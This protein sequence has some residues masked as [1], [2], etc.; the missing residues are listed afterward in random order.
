MSKHG[1]SPPE[2]VIK[3]SVQGERWEPFLV[4]IFVGIDIPPLYDDVVAAYLTTKDM[5]DP[6]FMVIDHV[7]Q[8]ISRELVRLEQYR[9]GR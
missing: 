2:S 1:W 9:V 6:H 7:G 4:T 3:V 5:S 8:M